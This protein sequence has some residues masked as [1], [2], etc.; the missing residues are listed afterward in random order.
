MSGSVNQHAVE[1]ARPTGLRT[2]GN[3]FDTL[4]LIGALAVMVGHAFILTGS[5]AP[6]VGNIPLHSFGVCVFF[7]ISGFLITQSWMNDRHIIRFV[8]RRILRII[9][10]LFVVTTCTALIIGALVTTEQKAQYYSHFW[11]WRYIF[12]N[13][14]LFTVWGLPGVFEHNPIP[15]QANGSLWTLPIEFGLYLI[16]PILGLQQRRSNFL[17]AMIVLCLAVFILAEVPQYRSIFTY[18]FYGIDLG[19]GLALAPYFLVGSALRLLDFA[20]WNLRDQRRVLAFSAFLV[21]F[22]TVSPIQVPLPVAMIGIVSLVLL[23][24]MSNWLHWSF[25]DRIGDLSYGSYLWAFPLQQLVVAKIGGGVWI[26]L[27]IVGPTTLGI[28]YLSWH[29]IERQALRLKPSRPAP[30][31]KP[32]PSGRARSS[33]LFV[34]R[35]PPDADGP[36][37]M[38]RA[39]QLLRVL[40]TQGEV[41]MVLLNRISDVE[42]A[43]SL[44]AEAKALVRK[45][46]AHT[47]AEWAPPRA[48]SRL[49]WQWRQI[50]E[51]IRIHAPDAPRFS[52]RTIAN[53]ASVLPEKRYDLV[54]AGRLS[55][56]C[57]VN[58][59]IAHGHLDSPARVVDLD[60][61]SSRFRARELSVLG[62][63]EGRLR[64]LLHR[65]IIR[66]LR[67]AE[68]HVCRTWDAVGL[69]VP[70]DL[71]WL[72][73]QVSGARL[74]L[75][76]NVIE[77]PRL[78]PPDG[79]R[80]RVLFV[81]HLSY[82]PN[83]DGLRM[84][85]DEVWPVVLR[86]LP[87]ATFAVV[88]MY[89]DSN[90]EQMV[91]AATNAQLYPNV[92]A[93][94]P[95]YQECD[96]VVS[97]IRYASG[98]RIKIIEA[99]AFGRAVVSTEIGAEGLKITHGRQALI[100]DDMADFADAVVR[101]CTD[102]ALNTSIVKAGH[103]LQQ[104]CYSLNA[105][106]KAIIEMIARLGLKTT[107]SPN[108]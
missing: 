81:G 48:N 16:V 13:S 5:S 91:A 47:I 41:D 38:Q 69:P 73:Q 11:T 24:G 54:F 23:I 56:A 106:T 10:A 85:L 36:G 53:I 104:E 55:S 86:A 80:A 26:N 66:R 74:Q 97:P 28:A 75:L 59:L 67:A 25:L 87:H 6:S 19:Q 52:R 96:V 57:I 71:A 58:Q 12:S 37:G 65:I 61:L 98:T 27:A 2:S 4:R 93:V 46:S 32:S 105:L 1:T 94:E 62:P 99:M 83:V 21:G 101:L 108:M 49:V 50:M 22:W 33:I 60:D 51:L 89:P 103:E 31:S 39:M 68:V 64:R 90:V 44:S 42:A 95:F 30:Q 100:A 63:T 18:S 84:F 88:G 45:F 78:P 17:A 79:V 82:T 35:L 9:P 8:K 7:S 34:T 43:T 107:P 40:A 20:A 15:G 3:S 72:Q 14:L 70:E 76:P 29:F 77:R 102:S 92:P